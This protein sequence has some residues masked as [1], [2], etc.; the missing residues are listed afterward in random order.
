MLKIA[1][2]L[3]DLKDVIA[4]PADEVIVALE[5]AAFSGSRSFSLEEI[6]TF[7]PS[8]KKSG[9]EVSVLVNKLFH[10]G[11]TENFR[12]QLKELTENG[13]DCFIFADPCVALWGKE[14]G[15]LN[16]LIYDPLTL[17]TSKEDALFW[18]D[19]KIA[20]VTLSPLVTSSEIETMASAIPNASIKAHGYSLMSV[21][22]RELV[23][24][25]LK[26]KN[27][28][29]LKNPED[30]SLREENRDYRLPVYEKEHMTLIYNDFVQETFSD[31]RNFM[32]HGVKRIEIESLRLSKEE[33]ND[34]INAYRRIAN[35]E[36][37]E[38]V[39]LEYYQRYRR[40]SLSEGYYGW[41]TVK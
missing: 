10:E 31:L 41:K 8:A 28:P 7:L 26:E 39:K 33:V 18:A 15:Y 36:D 23:T 3:Q 40:H 4:T 5:N 2:T 13:A 20:Y 11:E 16:K 17:V 1:V 12:A 21:S 25:Y 6:L 38:S 14:D 9:K 35:G 30:L 22:R 37:A 29:A 24:S 27:L 32:D 34:A 19:Q